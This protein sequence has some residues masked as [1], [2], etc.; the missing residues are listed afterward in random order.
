MGNEAKPVV[1]VGVDG[2]ELSAKAVVWADGYAQATGADLRLVTAWQW[3]TAYG[4]PMMF[5]GYDPPADAKVVMDKA[6]ADV[7]LTDDRVEIV[8]EKAPPDRYWSTAAEARR[9]LWSAAKGTAPSAGS[10]W[11]RPAPTASTTP[12]ARSSSFGDRPPGSGVD[13]FVLHLVG[14]YG[15]L[16][17]ALESK[18]CQTSTRSSSPSS[19]RGTSVRRS[20]DW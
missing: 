18:F 4:V 6:R 9:H 11:A 19:R 3:A 7:T 2:S 12:S 1:V 16:R 14:E 8:S 17:A 13:R 15:R 20:G 10:S 5:D